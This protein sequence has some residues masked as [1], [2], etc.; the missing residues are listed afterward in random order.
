MVIVEEIEYLIDQIREKGNFTGTIVP[1]GIP[2]NVVYN[3]NECETSLN[4]GDNFWYSK[5]P[6]F[7]YGTKQEIL[8]RLGQKSSE[9]KREKQIKYPAIF[10]EMPFTE[11]NFDDN[12]QVDLNLIFANKTEAGWLYKDRYE[13][14]IKPIIYP[15]IENFKTAV[16]RSNTV[17]AYDFMQKIDAPF[18]ADGGVIAN[19]IL[20]LVLIKTKITFINNCKKNKLCQ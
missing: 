7:Y 10:L 3:C 1:I 6:Y 9:L 20:D 17:V 11:L 18:Y 12:P 14:N 2:C 13:N 16:K 19:E 4:E 15:M 5:E 8:R